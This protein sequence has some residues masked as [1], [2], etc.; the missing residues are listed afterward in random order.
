MA[1]TCSRVRH[2]SHSRYTT[3]ASRLDSL[4]VRVVSAPGALR[5][6]RIP[7]PIAE[8]AAHRSAED[9]RGRP[10]LAGAEP[11]PLTVASDERQQPW[12][13]LLDLPRLDDTW[14]V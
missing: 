5:P 14:G 13:T 6:D 12:P 1:L 4:V 9:Q 8:A 3:I 7:V 11:T 2:Q 10:R